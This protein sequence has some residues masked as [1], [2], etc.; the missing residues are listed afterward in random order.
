MSGGASLT[1]E[2][3]RGNRCFPESVVLSMLCLCL[4]R[5]PWYVPL[6]FNDIML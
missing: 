3:F 5:W 1:D 6:V 4:L 2:L